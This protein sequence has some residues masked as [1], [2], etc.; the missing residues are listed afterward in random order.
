MASPLTIDHWPLTVY[1]I[2]YYIVYIIVY[3]YIVLLISRPPMWWHPHWPESCSPSHPAWW[4]PGGQKGDQKSKPGRTLVFLFF[5]NFWLFYPPCD[6]C[7]PWQ[8]HAVGEPCLIGNS[9]YS[10]SISFNIGKLRCWP[11]MST[12]KWRV[13]VVDLINLIIKALATI[14]LKKL[15]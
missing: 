15:P 5:F 7:A 2:I 6:A 4:T 8:L 3:T 10:C 9:K 14:S 13:A 12:K 11:I 1:S